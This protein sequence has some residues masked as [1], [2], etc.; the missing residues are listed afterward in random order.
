MTAAA[1]SR[2]AFR[3][4]SFGTITINER[5]RT[6]GLDMYAVTTQETVDKPVDFN[7][8]EASELHYWRKH[9]NLHGW[10]ETLYYARRAERNGSTAS[11][12]SLP[13]RTSTGSK[14]M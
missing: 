4:A 2:P 6:V 9:P 10:M 5:R 13:P 11:L 8:E 3:S 12:L 1:W 7:I 14:P